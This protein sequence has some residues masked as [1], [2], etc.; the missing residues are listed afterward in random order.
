MAVR[1]VVSYDTQTGITATGDSFIA[2]PTKQ[3][4]V[5]CILT[6][7]TPATGARVQ[8]TLD[9]ADKIT[10]G[11]ATWINSNLGNRVATGSENVIKPITGVRLVATDGT[12]TF[13]V[14][15]A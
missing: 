14:R 6:A 8:I 2:D 11:T 10:A 1:T 15:Q 7:G 5:A 12:W 9:E 4:N 13:S 3:V